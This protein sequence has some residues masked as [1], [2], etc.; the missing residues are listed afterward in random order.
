MMLR[1]LAL[2]IAP[3]CLLAACDPAPREA[4]AAPAAAWSAARAAPALSHALNRGA[5]PAAAVVDGAGTLHAVFAADTDHDGWADLLQYARLDSAGWSAPV[6]L[7]GG[8][9]LAEAPQLAI[10]GDGTLHLLWYAHTGTASPP[11]I[12]TELMHRALDGGRWSEPRVLYREPLPAGI[13]DLSL[14]AATGPDGA[15]EV[16]F[17]AQGRGIGHLTLRG[18]SASAPEFLDHDG[19]MTAFASAPAGR[20]LQLAYIGEAVSPLRPSAENDVFVRPLRS[21]LAWPDVEVH[22]VARR[23]SH[24]PQMVEDGD[25]GWHLFWLEDTDG[26]VFPE[27]LFHA[28]SRDGRNWGDAEDVTPAALRGGVFYRAAVVRG[29]G[30]RIHV[31]LRHTR[32][33]GKGDGLYA[34]TMEG[35]AP[36]P[37]ATL[38]APG[39]LG[40]GDAQLVPD[41]RHGRVI[42][43][44]RGTDGTVRWVTHGG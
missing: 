14:S 43:L 5:S 1:R 31:V 28:V 37:L 20:P 33:P 24:F 6:P 42:A 11:G 23:Y 27:A 3:L 41:A 44:W 8:G 16:L 32:D 12:P 22:S 4:Q 34:F 40:G 30:G 25:G 35:D 38:A 9:P 7:A 21:R 29:A 26:D 17:Q 13:P 39:Q 19:R 18:R 15:V 36:S 10:G 2:P